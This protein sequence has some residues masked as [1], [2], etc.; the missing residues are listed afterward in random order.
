MSNPL[1]RRSLYLVG[2]MGAGK[3][4]VGQL[5]ARQLNYRFFDTDILIE[6]LKGQSIT[7]IFKT[8]GETAFRHLETQVLAEVSSYLDCVVATGGGIVL[9]RENWSYLRHGIVVWLDLPVER[10]YARLQDDTSRPL[11]QEV[12]PFAELQRLLLQRQS[13]YAQAD[14]RVTLTGEETSEQVA[15][16]LLAEISSILIPEGDKTVASP[17]DP[18]TSR[19]RDR[20]PVT[21]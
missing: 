17:G 2:M 1:K 19:T 3:S 7:D 12:D 11:L 8:E 5:L 14:L 13:L 6:Q 18:A 16:R 21:E 4:T 20:P 10:L 9:K 15:S